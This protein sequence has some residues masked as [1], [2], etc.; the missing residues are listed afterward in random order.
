MYYYDDVNLRMEASLACTNSNVKKH[1]QSLAWRI[2]YNLQCAPN[3][4]IT[5]TPFSG[6]ALRYLQV[7]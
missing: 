6:F 5:F 7:L 4:A 3:Q 2:V 1:I